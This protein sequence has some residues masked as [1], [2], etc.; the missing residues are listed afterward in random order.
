[1]ANPSDAFGTYYFV[2]KDNSE[3]S[4]EC[5]MK[6]LDIMEHRL[7]HSSYSTYLSVFDYANDVNAKQ[8]KDN[9]KPVTEVN[10]LFDQMF[11]PEYYAFAVTFTGTGKWSYDATVMNLVSWLSLEK[12]SAASKIPTIARE[13]DEFFNTLG[14]DIINVVVKFTD[15]EPGSLSYYKAMIRTSINKNRECNYHEY[16]KIHKNMDYENLTAD[17]YI[18]D[19]DVEYY[20]LHH[21]SNLEQVL[22]QM[23]I[24]TDEEFYPD[25]V[26]REELVEKILNYVKKDLTNEKPELLCLYGTAIHYD[27]LDTIINTVINK[28]GNT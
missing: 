23:L 18:N 5:I 28:L 26:N 3:K 10:D 11:P 27:N 20:H 19:G 12:D 15:Y 8:I 24:E 9:L 25:S 16:Y 6:L 2:V 13:N 7:Y 14:D 21:D 17:R 4:A 22:K 1:M